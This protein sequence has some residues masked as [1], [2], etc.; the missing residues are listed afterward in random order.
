[1]D[2]AMK[3]VIDNPMEHMKSVKQNSSSVTLET[4][5]EQ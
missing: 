5:K 3:K 2:I 1:M 4:E